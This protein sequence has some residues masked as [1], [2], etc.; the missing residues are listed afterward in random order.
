MVLN[1]ARR[2]AFPNH[3]IVLP[4]VTPHIAGSATLRWPDCDDQRGR[5]RHD[6][7]PLAKVPGVGRHR[8]ELAEGENSDPFQRRDGGDAALPSVT[9]AGLKYGPLCDAIGA[10]LPA[11]PTQET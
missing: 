10:V 11:E 6:N 4:N 2:R 9:A 7:S 5:R 3:A 8:R 1:V